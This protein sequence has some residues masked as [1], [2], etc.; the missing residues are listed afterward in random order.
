MT[1]ITRRRLLTGAAAGAAALPFAQ[2]AFAQGRLTV[3]SYGGTWEKAQRE[4]YAPVFKSR[5]AGWD[6][7]VQLGGPPQ[8]LSQIEAN[9][10]AP[11]IH[12]SL[13]PVEL[14]LAGG[15]KGLFEKI[16]VDK[17]P[18]LADVPKPFIDMCEGWGV[19]VN[20]GAAVFGYHKERVKNPPKSYKELVERVSK[21][22]LRAALPGI[23]W[24]FTPT[25]LLWPLAQAFGGGVDNVTPG[26]EAVKR[27]KP[28]SVFWNSVTEFP[29]LLQSGE[30]DVGIWYDGRIWDAYD[31]GAKWLAPLNPEEGA[32]MI[33]ASVVKVKNAPDIG[34]K[35]VDAMLDPEAQ[36]KFA[37]L[38]NYPITNSKVVFPP[39]L[40]ERFTP[41][42][43]T[44]LPPFGKIAA[45]IPEWVNR[46]NREL[47]G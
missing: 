6:V 20:Y 46:W 5:N 25:I 19:C 17:V 39:E 7:D 42:E 40:R 8:W 35:Y 27:M 15:A 44:Q 26:F 18:N 30:A 23:G 41:W 45:V 28:N 31:A 3:T 16:S 36:L 29:Q 14:A 2:S 12:V 1:I 34:W 22:E 4:I 11:P 32:A 21:G 43:K 10:S 38:I 9:A 47:R 24:A 33:P 37:K 13:M